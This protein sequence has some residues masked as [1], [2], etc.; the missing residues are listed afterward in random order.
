MTGSNYRKIPALSIVWM[1]KSPTQKLTKLLK[2]LKL[3]FFLCGLQLTVN[4]YVLLVYLLSAKIIN[5]VYEWLVNWSLWLCFILFTFFIC[6]FV[7]FKFSCTIGV[8]LLLHLWFYVCWL[9]VVWLVFPFE[10]ILLLICSIY[11]R[12][13]V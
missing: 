10:S 1:K 4:Y 7:F 6:G 9:R 3:F 12:L 5:I 13:Y 8:L 11:F 2:C